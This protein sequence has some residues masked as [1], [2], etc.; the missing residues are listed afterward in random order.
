MIFPGSAHYQYLQIVTGDDYPSVS[1]SRMTE[2]T[3]LILRF[4]NG[5]QMASLYYY[6]GNFFHPVFLASRELEL[7]VR[8]LIEL[9]THKHKAM[10]KADRAHPDYRTKIEL[11]E[12]QGL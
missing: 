7:R 2:T 12:E 9:F 1:E 3:M 8:R 5:S 11:A 10:I 4:R 6:N